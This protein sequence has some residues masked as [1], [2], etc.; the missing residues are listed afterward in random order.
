[1]EWG[2]QTNGAKHIY[3]YILSTCKDFIKKRF[4]TLLEYGQNGISEI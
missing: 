3:V 4:H 1:M 2:G